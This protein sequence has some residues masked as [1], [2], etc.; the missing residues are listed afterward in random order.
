MP[1]VGYLISSVEC[2]SPSSKVVLE[3]LRDSAKRHGHPL[4]VLTDNG[5][6]F[7]PVIQRQRGQ[8]VCSRQKWCIKNR[9]QYARARRKEPSS[10]HREGGAVASHD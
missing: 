3:T 1:A 4:Q 9:V 10:D 5:S 8:S 7:V 2:E 6:V